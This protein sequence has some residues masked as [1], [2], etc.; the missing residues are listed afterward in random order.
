MVV[1]N[2]RMKIKEHSKQLFKKVIE[3]HKSG[4]GY[5]NVSKSLNIPKT[6]LRSL[7][8]KWKEYGT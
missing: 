1:K 7:N 3:K 4:D 2:C 5:K 8:K 6:T